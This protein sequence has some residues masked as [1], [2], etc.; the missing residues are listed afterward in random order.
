[1]AD[2]INQKQ[3]IFADEFILTGN[4][5]QSYQKAYNCN[6]KTAEANGSDLLRNTKVKKYIEEVNKEIHDDTIADMKEVKQFWTKKMRSVETEDK[7]RLKASEY[8]A[9]TNGAFIEKTEH[10]GSIELPQIIIT[11]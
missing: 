9:K 8:I 3:K 6:I 7:D 11:K 1:M 4:A 5:T 2:D 10:S